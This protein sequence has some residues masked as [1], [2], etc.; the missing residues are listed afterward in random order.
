M[1]FSKQDK[2]NYINALERKIDKKLS[3]RIGRQ[4]KAAVKGKKVNRT[5]NND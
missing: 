2:K 3:K 1:E 4:Q 5:Q